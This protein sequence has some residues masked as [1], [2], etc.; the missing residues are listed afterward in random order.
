MSALMGRVSDI[1]D[2]LQPMCTDG[3]AA[4]KKIHINTCKLDD[5][6]NCP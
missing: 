4:K 3:K 1:E 2:T 6:E 5:L